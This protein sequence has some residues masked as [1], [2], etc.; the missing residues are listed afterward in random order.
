MS[1]GD[2]GS[3][4]FWRASGT[5]SLACAYVI[6]VS[7]D[8]DMVRRLE[9]VAAKT[10][11]TVGKA[12][13]ITPALV[14]GAVPLLLANWFIA[15]AILGRDCVVLYGGGNITECGGGLSEEEMSA[16]S[17]LIALVVLVIQ[18]GLIFLVRR[19]T[20]SGPQ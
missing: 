12:R 18:L 13:Y 5:R 14:L 20:R 4:L 19:H 11:P 7:S 9:P 10:E 6:G 8:S 16:A 15:A 17:G 3:R 2:R 1:L